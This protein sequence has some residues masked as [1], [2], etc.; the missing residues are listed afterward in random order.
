MIPPTTPTPPRQGPPPLVI[1]AESQF[2]RM[3]RKKDILKYIVQ[4]VFG[5]IIL[6]FSAVQI[7]IYPDE[8][9]QVWIGL[10]CAVIGIFFPHP[11]PGEDEI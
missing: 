7:S 2:S 8:A 9:N 3:A 6:I 4:S 1:R 11:S 10:I 5:L